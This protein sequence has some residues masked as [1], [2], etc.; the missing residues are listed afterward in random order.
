MRRSPG[1]R[2]TANLSESTHHNLNMYALAA[3]AAGVG[4]LA[5]AD[6]AEAK[7]V[8]TPT[9]IPIVM[10]GGPVELDLNHDGINDFE[11][12]A[13]SGSEPVKGL[14]REAGPFVWFDWWIAPAQSANRV[15]VEGWGG[16]LCAAARPRGAKIGPANEFQP[17][18]SRLTMAAGEWVGTAGGRSWCPWGWGKD[19]RPDSY[20]GLKFVINGTTHFGWAHINR[21]VIT[22]YA[23]ETVP[24]KPILTGATKGTD[25][26]I[27]TKQPNPASLSTPTA[28]PA[29]LGALAAGSPGLSIWRRKESALNRN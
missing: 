11:F 8:Y 12:S 2:K 20:L 28:G 1:L 27:G 25:E 6:P 5:L 19:K 23:Y 13:T 15:R 24:N 17:G 4:L 10:N 7:I 16:S 21:M 29:T 26:S 18:Y 3:G 22:G 14:R 9:N